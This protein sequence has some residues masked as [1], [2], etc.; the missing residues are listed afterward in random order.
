MTAEKKRKHELDDDQV[1]VLVDEI[2]GTG[3]PRVLHAFLILINN[4]A[5]DPTGVEALNARKWGFTWFVDLDE[6]IITKAVA[7]V[8][9]RFLATGS[10]EKI[11][12]KSEKQKVI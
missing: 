2:L 9:E 11:I 10:V 8:T 5:L 3:D 12:R 7:P 1:K 6:S 4:I